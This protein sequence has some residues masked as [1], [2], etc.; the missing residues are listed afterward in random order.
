MRI[1]GKRMKNLMRFPE[2]QKF[3]GEMLLHSAA[4]ATPLLSEFSAWLMAGLGAAFALFI[5]NLDS[6]TKH[7]DPYNFRWAMIWFAISLLLGLIARFLSVMVLSGLTANR[8]F[9]QKAAELSTARASFF[10][11]FFHLYFQGLLLPYRCL[12]VRSFNKVK[13]GDLMA[14][15]RQVAKTSQLQALLILAQILVTFISVA[16][17]ATGIK[18]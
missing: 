18:V 9:A 7:L 1:R 10:P 3:V 5:A 12:A 11:A 6:V 13:R 4:I 16:V 15:S 14:S 8:I 2:Q 17:L